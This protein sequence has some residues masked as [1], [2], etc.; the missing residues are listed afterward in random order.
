MR[1]D[2][3][4][5]H[6]RSRCCSKAESRTHRN[7]G[8]RVQP[9]EQHPVGKADIVRKCL[10]PTVVEAVIRKKSLELGGVAES[11]T[12]IDDGTDV[13]LGD[14]IEFERSG[15]VLAVFG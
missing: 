2:A 3:Q 12:R 4:S 7:D 11:V 9:S 13:P 10:N 15:N 8:H 5:M 1:A 14:L 6:P